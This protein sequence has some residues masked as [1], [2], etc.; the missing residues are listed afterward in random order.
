MHRIIIPRS[1]KTR[2][3][4]KQR[5]GFLRLQDIQTKVQ[6]SKFRHNRKTAVE[7]IH[8]YVSLVESAYLES[9]V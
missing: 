3:T 7:I 1:S 8:V 2:Q 6:T 4:T 9:S 5:D